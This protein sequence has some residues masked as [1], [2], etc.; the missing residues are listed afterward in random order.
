MFNQAMLSNAPLDVENSEKRLLF[1]PFF[2]TVEG[3]FT[4]LYSNTYAVHNICSATSGIRTS[5]M[6][7]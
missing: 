5:S 1:V 4:S 7:S 2:Q 3:D 6:V